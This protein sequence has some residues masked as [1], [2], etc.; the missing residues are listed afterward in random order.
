MVVFSKSYDDEI[1]R[2]DCGDGYRVT[3]HHVA[4]MI[5]YRERETKQSNM[6]SQLIARD[7]M[8]IYRKGMG[9]KIYVVST[10]SGETIDFMTKLRLLFT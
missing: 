5:R 1:G 8:W 7:L 4:H 10:N 6:M 3:R 2:G 9:Q